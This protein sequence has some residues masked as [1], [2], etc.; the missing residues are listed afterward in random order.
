MAKSMKNS[1]A[2]TSALIIEGTAL[3]N[4]ITAIF[5]PSFLEISLKG[6]RT[7]SIRI[8]LINSMFRLLKMIEM[9]E[10]MMMKKSMIFQETLRYDSGPF[11]RR[12]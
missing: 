12:P 10:K 1:N 7:L 6:L 11:I 3:I 4:D 8:T 2:I 9:S 5:N